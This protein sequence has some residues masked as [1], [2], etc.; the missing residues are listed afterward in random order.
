MPTTTVNAPGSFA[1]SQTAGLGQSHIFAAQRVQLALMDTLS[2]R[3]TGMISLRGDLAGTGSDTLRM[4]EIDGVGFGVRFSA[5][6][7]ETDAVDPSTFTLGY[8]EVTVAQYGLSH[9]QTFHDQ[10]LSRDAGYGL[11]DMVRLVPCSVEATLRYLAC[12]AGSG[13]SGVIGSA[14]TPLDV[15]AWL[16][17][18]TGV[19]ET[20][21]AAALGAPRATLAPQQLTQL[22][23]AFR[24]EP[25]YG[26]SIAEFASVQGLTAP[27]VPNLAGLGID[28]VLTDDVQQS[29]GAYQGF[30]GSPGFMGWARASTDRI[31]PLGAVG[32]MYMPEVGLIIVPITDGHGN[33]TAQY[34]AYMWCGVAVGSANLSYQTR[35]RSVV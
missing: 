18:S 7:S 17:L 11:A 5:M 10:V 1:Q 33:S 35:I 9:A 27:F 32:A 23:E 22:I 28:V 24:A 16:A 3:A 8:S 21:G 20:S 25:A 29:G 26:E 14:T 4:T 34:V 31:L 2:F 6:G 12:V 19:R 13:I 30:A 15:D